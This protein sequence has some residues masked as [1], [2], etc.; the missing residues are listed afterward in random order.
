MTKQLSENEK[1]NRRIN[2]V[3]V[4]FTAGL[5]F[6]FNC[7][8]E[9]YNLEIQEQTY[10]CLGIFVASIISLYFSISLDS[11]NQGNF[12]RNFEGVFKICAIILIAF[13]LAVIL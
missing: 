12:A 10:I 3:I 11:K 5:A 2:F 13:I 8:I 9:K 1:Y 6:G 4:L 7:L